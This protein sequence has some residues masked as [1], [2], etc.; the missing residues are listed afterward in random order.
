MAGVTA[1]PE[2]VIGDGAPAALTLPHRFDHRGD[3]VA[4]GRLGSGP[5]LVLIHGTPFSSQVWR[6]IVPWLARRWTLHWFDLLGYGQSDKRA[7]QDV[8]LGAQNGLLAALL[9]EWGLERPAVLAHDIGGATALRG[10]YLD[11][12][13]YSALTLVDPVAVAPWGSPFVAHVRRHEDA[14]AGMPGYAH[15]ALLRAY[16]QGAAHRPLD[17]AALAVHAGPWLGSEGQTAFYRQIAQ[18]DVRHTDEIEPLYGPMDCEVTLLWGERDEWIPIERGRAL[19][20]RIA[21]GRLMVVPKCGHLV[22]EDAP[23]AI[24]AAML[25]GR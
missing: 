19:A 7:G 10:W 2:S 21:G 4:W 1:R 22:Q 18:L 6:R 14:F 8:S 23:E 13:R 9:D 11:G 5:P 20:E 16:L 25:G 3:A 17:E 12:L 24:V 15:E